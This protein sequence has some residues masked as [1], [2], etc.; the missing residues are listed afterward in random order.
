MTSL[1]MNLIRGPVARGTCFIVGS[2]VS[3]TFR[4]RAAP[5]IRNYASKPGQE[6]TGSSFGGSLFSALVGAGVGAGGY[7]YWTTIQGKSGV[8]CD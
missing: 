3:N 1:A 8:R 6:G 7:Y 4:S 5:L 2:Q